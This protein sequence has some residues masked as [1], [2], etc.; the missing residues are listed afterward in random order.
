MPQIIKSLTTGNPPQEL[1][2]RLDININVTG[3]GVSVGVSE[4]QGQ[5]GVTKLKDLEPEIPNFLSNPVDLIQF[6]EEAN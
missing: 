1:I 6:G 4:P 3:S 5:S 2:I